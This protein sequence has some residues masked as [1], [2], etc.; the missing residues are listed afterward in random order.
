MRLEEELAEAM[1]A[2]VEGIHAPS[3]MGA[4]VRHRHRV[5]K[6]RVRTAGVVLA[7][8]TVA[9]VMPAGRQIGSGL[10][11]NLE[12]RPGSASTQEATSTQGAASTQGDMSVRVDTSGKV[13]VPTVIDLTRERAK[14]VL[15]AAGFKA[16]VL[17][18][19]R[20]GWV[21]RQV[22]DGGQLVPA[23]STVSLVLAAE[24]VPVP[25]VPNS[26]LSTL[27][28][29]EKGSEPTLRDPGDGREFGG[30]RFGYLPKDLIWTRSTTGVA[31]G[32]DGSIFWRE[33][34][35][36]SD[37]YS[38][39][40][41]VFQRKTTLRFKTAGVRDAVV[42]YEV[43]AAPTILWAPRP[44]LMVQVELSVEYAAKLTKADYATK[45]GKDVKADKDSY[46]DYAAKFG[47]AVIGREL[48]K[49]ANA[50]TATE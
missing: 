41:V 21:T 6:V 25:T 38:V 50:I 12:A 17:K 10:A 24:P 42:T 14:A 35:L 40:A 29:A 43:G 30:V 8:V 49:I 2:Q 33:S 32:E 15:K 31:S 39:R 36:P 9:V 5:R 48:R 46:A 16:V 7:T 47:K 19:L 45:L 34:G 18:D 37:R 3:V 4:V 13:E 26:L 27:A 20:H 28:P 44:D 23:G 11:V 1:R 22:P